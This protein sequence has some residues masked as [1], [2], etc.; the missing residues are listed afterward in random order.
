LNSDAEVTNSPSSTAEF[1]QYADLAPI[2]DKHGLVEYTLSFDLKSADITNSDAI[3]VYCQNGSG[4][5]YYIGDQAFGGHSVSVTTEYKRYSITFTP[6]IQDETETQ[7]ILAF[8]GTY[9]T[10]NIPSV[11]NVKIELGNKATDWTPAPEDVDKDIADAQGTA[12]EAKDLAD[13]AYK[14]AKSQIEIL[15]DQVVTVV[16]DDNGESKL[17][18]NSN[19][20]IFNTSDL[21]NRFDELNTYV[22]IGEYDPGNGQDKEACI[23]LGVSKNSLTAKITNTRMVYAD[24]DNPLVTIDSEKQAM[25]TGVIEVHDYQQYGDETDPN[26]SGVW[27]WKLRPNGNLGLSWKGVTS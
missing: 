12:N 25:E 21:Q 1:V 13:D 2:F 18:Q 20:W 24:G 4:S 23:D 22:S 15:A 17:V 16:T 9:G 27:Q 19:G 5:K 26:L 11:K 6:S 7:S 3:S 10:G 8:Y 14:Y